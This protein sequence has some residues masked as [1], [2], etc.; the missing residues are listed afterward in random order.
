MK[1]IRDY[2]SEIVHLIEKLEEEHGCTV[3]SI[4]IVREYPESMGVS[5]SIRT[6]ININVS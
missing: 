3:N 4:D 1:S 5:Y 2:K 6:I